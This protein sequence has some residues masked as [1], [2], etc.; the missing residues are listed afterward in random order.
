MCMWMCRFW[1]LF[2]TKSHHQGS[3]GNCGSA[4]NVKRS[5]RKTIGHISFL[6]G[7]GHCWMLRRRSP[8]HTWWMW[9]SATLSHQFMPIWSTDQNACIC[10]F[11]G[12]VLPSDTA[13]GIMG[14]IM[15]HYKHR[16]IPINQPAQ[17][18]AIKVLNAAKLVFGNP[19][20]RWNRDHGHSN[21]G[22]DGILPFAWKHARQQLVISMSWKVMWKMRPHF[23]HCPSAIVMW[24]HRI[25]LESRRQGPNASK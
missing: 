11:W 8:C 5:A 19:P 7:S 1:C 12:V 3:S 15:S 21:S 4:L 22:M 17:W 24:E 9:S 20:F 18:N 10:G 6:Q 2:R 23:N 13:E 16:R 25:G 14:V